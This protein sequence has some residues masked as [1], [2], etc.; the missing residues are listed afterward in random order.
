[1]EKSEG[2]ENNFMK[3][4][5]VA[6][7][8]LWLGVFSA[9]AQV[10]PPLTLQ[11]TIPLPGVTGKFDHFAYDPVGNRLFAAAAGNHSVEVVDL[12][13]DKVLESL[14][15]LGKPHGLAWIAETGRLFAS[16]GVLGDL[17][18]YDGAPL[19]P[20]KSIA[21][22]DDADDMVY[23][24]KTKLLYVGHGGSPAHPAMIA[25]VDTTNQALVTNLPV[26]THPEGLEI[27]TVNDRIFVNIA[28]AAEVAVIDGATHT[29]SATWKLKRAKDNVPLVYDEEQQVLFV[30]CRTPARLVVLDGKSGHE[31]ADLPTDAGADD[32]FYDAELH[33]VYLIAG[34]GAVD[35]FEIDGS[36]KVRALGVAHT[37]AGAKTGLLV[38]SQHAL[39][40]G[41]PGEQPAIMVYATR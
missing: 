38:P 9:Q 33:R 1:L 29:R 26:A 17:K 5:A 22:S 16:D 32:I 18:A 4:K 19:K 28:D 37:S 12:S 25:V 41:V 39:Y 2:R 11:R 21:L 20:M 14:T 40:V 30:A 36:R 24:A 3:I 6:A 35:V 10:A 34:G 8:L 13:S 7:F 23:D 27:D 15:G 31:L